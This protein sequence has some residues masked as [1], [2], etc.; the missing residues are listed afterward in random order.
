MEKTKSNERD[1][2]E[3]DIAVANPKTEFDEVELAKDSN[4]FTPEE[5]RALVRKI[6]LWI[7]PL[8]EFC[9]HAKVPFPWV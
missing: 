5:E 4:D 2:L 6:D 8:S 3:R 1:T 9:F 7:V